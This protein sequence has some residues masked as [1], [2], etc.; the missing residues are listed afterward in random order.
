LAHGLD[1]TAEKGNRFSR[2]RTFYE[3]GVARQHS[4]FDMRVLR[5]LQSITAIGN[6]KGHHVRFRHP[7]KG[8]FSPDELL[9]IRNA[10]DAGNGSEKDRALVMLHLELGHNPSATARLKNS[11]LIRYEAAMLIR[12][13]LDVP[14][15]KKRTAHRE[16]K[17]RPISNKLGILLESLQAGSSGDPLIHWLPGISPDSSITHALRRFARSSGLVSPRTLKPLVVNARRF[18]FSTATHMAEEGAS[19]FHI[20]EI[21]DHTD[22]QNVRVYVQTVSSIAD[23]VAKATDAALAPLVRRF[24]GKIVDA[25][26]TQIFDGLPNQMIPAAAPHLG[27]VHLNAGGVGMCGRDVRKDG[28]CRL[29]PPVSCYLCPSFAALSDGPHQEMLDSIEAFLRESEATSDRRIKMQLD[30]VR[31]AIQQVIRQVREQ[32]A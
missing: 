11:D 28:L 5:L 9:L 15:V 30:E 32:G 29:L 6:A 12:Y 23:P 20:A 13:H 3:W 14:R 16:T 19:L 17:R 1:H 10:I 8:P 31:V 24:Q 22:T 25:S 26:E 27:I 21:L 7:T 4:D 18:R 2:I